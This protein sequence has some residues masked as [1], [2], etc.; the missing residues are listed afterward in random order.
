MTKITNQKPKEEIKKEVDEVLE[1]TKPETP[2]EFKIE[3]LLA[4]NSADLTAPEMDFLSEHKE[5][6]TLEQLVAVGLEDPEIDPEPTPV[7]PT[8]EPVP[9]TPKV[10]PEPVVPEPVPVEVKEVTEPTDEELK[11]YVLKDGVDIDELTT[12]EKATARRNYIIEKRQEAINKGFEEQKKVTDW[13]KKVDS[14]LDS[15]NNDPKFAGLDGHEAEFKKFA[16]QHPESDIEVLL[17]PA[18]LH[19]LP[20]TPPKRG[21]LFEKGGGGQAP[22]KPKEGIDDAE[23]AK[24]LREKDPKEYKRLVKA[25]KIKLEVD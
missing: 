17:L 14:F 5:D 19:Q 3:D 24:Q 22:P 18:F 8:P 11:A 21:S 25:G 9:E 23:M 13:S 12:F 6:L 16:L 4:K 7:P 10:E 1:A 20:A 2:P 15:T